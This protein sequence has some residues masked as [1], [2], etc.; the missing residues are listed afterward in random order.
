MD[1]SLLDDRWLIEVGRCESGPLGSPTASM[2][3]SGSV[4]HPLKGKGACHEAYDD[5]IGF[6]KASVSGACG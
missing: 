3:Q 1:A 4:C 2:C 6:G 5:R